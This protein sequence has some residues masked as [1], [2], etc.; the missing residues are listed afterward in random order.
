MPLCFGDIL[1][2][3]W[4]HS[5]PAVGSVAMCCVLPTCIWCIQIHCRDI[6]SLAHA[7]AYS[8][9]STIRRVR[10]ANMMKVEHAAVVARLRGATRKTQ[11]KHAIYSNVL[12]KRHKLSGKLK[13]LHARMW[14]VCVRASHHASGKLTNGTHQ[15]HDI[16]RTRQISD[17]QTRHTSRSTFMR[18]KKWTAHESTGKALPQTTATHMPVLVSHCARFVREKV[19][20]FT[21]KYKI[22]Y[23]HMYSYVF[24]VQ[25]IKWSTAV[26]LNTILDYDRPIA[27]RRLIVYVC[28]CVRQG[29]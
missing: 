28:V 9:P 22:Q 4:N 26:T 18:R 27:C 29:K 5:L 6:T 7:F 1:R 12:A 23:T 24:V 25:K 21:A 2:F 17:I 14:C 11:S 10:V 8:H 16:C 15:T 3:H 20:T 13:I 19:F